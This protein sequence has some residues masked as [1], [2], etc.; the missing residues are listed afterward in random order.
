MRFRGK[1]DRVRH[2][3]Y[4]TFRAGNSHVRRNTREKASQPFVLA[5]SDSVH[6]GLPPLLGI[7]QTFANEEKRGTTK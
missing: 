2:S 7:G 1:G 6:R 5:R 4:N 3:N